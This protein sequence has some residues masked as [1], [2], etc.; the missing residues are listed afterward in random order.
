MSRIFRYLALAGLI[1][2]LFGLT[3]GALAQRFVDG[4]FE[5]TLKVSGSVDVDVSTGSG[6]IEV[7]PGAP[8]EL[9]IRATVRVGHWNR[10]QSE[11]EQVLIRLVNNPPIEQIGSVIKIGYDSPDLP[12]DISIS[13]QITVPKETRLH[14]RTGSGNQTI[15]GIT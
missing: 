10:S 3:I 9:T 1:L 11:A 6:R 4:S 2:L 12:H 5:R 13:Y 15:D 7:Q 8:D 14:S